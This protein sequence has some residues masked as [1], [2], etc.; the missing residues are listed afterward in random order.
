[1]KKSDTAYC[2]TRKDGAEF[3]I[4]MEWDA[5]YQGW[6]ATRSLSPGEALIRVVAAFSAPCSVEIGSGLS[7]VGVRFWP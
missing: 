1:M 2:V 5:S 6:I 4:P 7:V 3:T